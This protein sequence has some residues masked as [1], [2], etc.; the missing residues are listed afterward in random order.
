MYLFCVPVN[1]QASACMKD[2]MSA[3][4]LSWPLRARFQVWNPMQQPMACV[5][6]TPELI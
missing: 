6:L 4:F 2:A 3:I 5:P 1:L